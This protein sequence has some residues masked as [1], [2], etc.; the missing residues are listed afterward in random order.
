MSDLNKNV[1]LEKKEKYQITRQNYINMKKRIE[2]DLKFYNFIL[3]F[4][5][6]YLI[7]L[8]ITNIYFDSIL[9]DN[10]LNYVSLTLSIIL[11][12]ISLIIKPIEA[13][14]NM[15]NLKNGILKLNFLISEI[16]KLESEKASEIESEYDEL[17]KEMINRKDI[18]YYTTSKELIKKIET[19]NYKNG[20][21]Q[22]IENSFYEKIELIWNKYRYVITILL[23]I[24]FG[25][26]IYSK[27]IG[28][29][30]I[31]YTS[32]IVILVSIAYYR[33]NKKCK[34][35]IKDSEIEKD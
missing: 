23:F 16:E 32:V 1:I 35:I 14:N 17:M 18:D 4:G 28:N 11:Y 6:L 2:S 3:T 21:K 33:E 29:L 13:N 22:A 7:I 25:I 15:N 27:N 20:M 5:A 19:K 31:V 30:A 9:N 26:W 12:T 10:I 8:T 24:F 34:K